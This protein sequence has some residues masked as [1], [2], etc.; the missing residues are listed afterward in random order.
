MAAQD[1][2]ATRQRGASA[3][4]IDAFAVTPDDGADLP[5]VARALYVGSSGDVNAVTL[6]GTTVR[7]KAV[8]AGGI[9]PCSIT[10]VLSTDTTASDIVALV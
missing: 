3:P 10:R 8:S 6:G 1:P 2:F 7:F 9:L 4:A 5:I